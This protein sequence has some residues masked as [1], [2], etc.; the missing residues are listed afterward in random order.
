MDST[1][2]H[3]ALMV[4]IAGY[5]ERGLEPSTY[6][7]DG[8]TATGWAVASRHISRDTYRGPGDWEDE[9]TWGLAVLMKDGTFFECTLSNFE[10]P[11]G[12]STVEFSERVALPRYREYADRP[13]TEHLGMEFWV[14]RAQIYPAYVVG[15][16]S[17]FKP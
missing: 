3:D 13:E 1:Q 2:A 10:R 6:V 16:H 15:N 4:A 5:A 14:D 8:D 7:W 11:G 9:V 17:Y 12:K